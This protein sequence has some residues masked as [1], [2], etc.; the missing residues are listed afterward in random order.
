MNT[1]LVVLIVAV[2][3]VMLAVRHVRASV[4][5]AAGTVPETPSVISQAQVSPAVL[6][7]TVAAEDGLSDEP[8]TLRKEI[9]EI[10]Q[11][12]GKEIAQ[13]RS[14]YEVRREAARQWEA[15]HPRETPPPPPTLGELAARR[16]EMPEY[17]EK[18]E[19]LLVSSA[20]KRIQARQIILQALEETELTDEQ[21]SA[22]QEY[23][24]K[25]DEIDA[26][27]TVR[28]Y[29]QE[30]MMSLFRNIPHKHELDQLI[31]ETLDPDTIFS[32]EMIYHVSASVPGRFFFLHDDMRAMNGEEE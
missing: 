18:V 4:P 7:P 2:W 28:E 22:I 3:A 14:E 15:E 12:S 26:S 11:M 13:M 6:E 20:Q 16:E 19:K 29:T 5:L 30:D 9:R 31:L 17:Y 10:R 25:L 32:S 8:A 27:I 21:L 24:A 23:F 1:F